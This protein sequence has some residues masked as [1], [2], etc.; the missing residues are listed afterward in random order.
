[1]PASSRVSGPYSCSVFPRQSTVHRV[2]VP[3][4]SSRRLRRVRF[5]CLQEQFPDG[6]MLSNSPFH[7]CR[8]PF[9][10]RRCLLGCL[11]Y[12]LISYNPPVA[13]ASQ[14]FDEQSK[15]PQSLELTER[16]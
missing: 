2:R 13:G 12:P 7:V 8:R 5:D 16:C 9:P 6:T 11:V 15:F 14:D 4:P 10:N 3:P 1:M